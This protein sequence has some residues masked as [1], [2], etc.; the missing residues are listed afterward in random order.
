MLLGKVIIQLDATMKFIHLNMFIAASSWI[1]TLPS[2]T[3]HGHMN[4]KSVMLPL[5]LRHYFYKNIFKI[6]QKLY[7]AP[8]SVPPNENFWVRN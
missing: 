1:I 6:K 2:F 3:M 8:G 5:Y 4:I 7:I